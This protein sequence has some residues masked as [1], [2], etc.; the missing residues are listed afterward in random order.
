ML[1]GGQ[2]L[3]WVGQPE[4]IAGPVAFLA[5]EDGRRITGTVLDAPGGTYLGPTR[6]TGPRGRQ[7]T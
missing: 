7:G 3:P 4:D 2:A 6:C 1:I 5:S